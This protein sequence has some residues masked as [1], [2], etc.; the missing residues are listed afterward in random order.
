MNKRIAIGIVALA[1]VVGAAVA[2]MPS[3]AARG[4]GNPHAP[5][6]I[7]VTSQGLFYDTFAPVQSLPP[8]GRFQLLEVGPM[9][10]QTEFGPGDPG[11]LGGRWKLSDGAGGYTYFL[12][13]YTHSV[14]LGYGSSA[15]R[16]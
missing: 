4:Q 10:P 7:Y 13:P 1:L 11:Y 14:S 3:A 6:V 12:C 16:S 8:N 9:G 15:H 2:T 5:G